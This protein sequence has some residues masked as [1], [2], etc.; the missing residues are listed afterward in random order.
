MLSRRYAVGNLARLFAHPKAEA[1]RPIGREDRSRRS[2]AWQ[3]FGLLPA[4]ARLFPAAGPFF[5]PAVADATWRKRLTMIILGLHFGHDAAAAVLRD[6]HVVS[7]VLRERHS[8]IKHAITLDA[9]TID[10][11]LSAAGVSARDLDCVAI[12]STQGI[13]LIIDNS[14]RLSIALRRH[15]NTQG[16][17][18]LEEVIARQRINPSDIAGGRLQSTLDDPNATTTAQYAMYRHF[19]P[20]YR[21]RGAINP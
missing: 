9:S 10:R 12:T 2:P 18:S 13:E 16:R 15:A 19:Y 20:E 11:A 1:P 8:R 14:Q 3:R 7:C 4:R 5:V 6:G 21:T 17:S